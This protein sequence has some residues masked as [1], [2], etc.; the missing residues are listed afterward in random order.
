LAAKT[1]ENL[2][3]MPITEATAPALFRQLVVPR[4]SDPYIRREPRQ[5]KEFRCQ[6]QGMQSLVAPQAPAIL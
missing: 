4:D 2:I 5:D 3:T 1:W 6:A